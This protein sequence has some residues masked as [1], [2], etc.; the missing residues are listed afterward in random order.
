[1]NQAPRFDLGTRPTEQDEIAVA[2]FIGRKPAGQFSVI[3]RRADNLPAVIKNAPLMFDGTP[4][5]TLYWLV[6]PDLVREVGVI[7]SSGGVD[8]AEAEVDEVALRACHRRYE[9]ER[10][11]LL[12]PNWQGPIPSGGVGGTRRGVKCLHAHYAY[13]LGGGEDPVAQWLVQKL[14]ALRRQQTTE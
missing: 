7:E 9:D 14:R 2:G 13:F 12:P 3:V 11:S 8:R 6:D 1:M 5:P 10:N 4:M